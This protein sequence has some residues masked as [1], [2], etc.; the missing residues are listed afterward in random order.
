MSGGALAPSPTTSRSLVKVSSIFICS[1]LPGD[2]E[3]GDAE[4]EIQPAEQRALRAEDAAEHAVQGRDVDVVLG[5]GP[6]ARDFHQ[7]AAEQDRREESDV[8]VGRALDFEAGLAN[9][10]PQVRDSVAATV[11]AHVVLH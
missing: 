3:G 1:T 5:S 6:D 11:V 8:G 9:G 4:R 10:P 2:A 7:R